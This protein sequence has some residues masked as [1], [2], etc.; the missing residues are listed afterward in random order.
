MLSIILVGGLFVGAMALLLISVGNAR[1]A[2][3]A[4]ANSRP[5]RPVAVAMDVRLIPR[6]ATPSAG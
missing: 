6:R 5:A 4:R 2:R 3:I 1:V